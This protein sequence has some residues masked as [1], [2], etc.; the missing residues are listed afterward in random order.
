MSIVRSLYRLTS[1]TNSVAAIQKLSRSIPTLFNGL[2]ALG[3]PTQKLLKMC[4]N[5][6][7]NEER[8]EMIYPEVMVK[9]LEWIK[10]MNDNEQVFLAESILNIC[11]DNVNW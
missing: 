5:L 4:I 2:K 7:Y 11:A 1:E 9:L 10:D 3:R 8:G 6:A